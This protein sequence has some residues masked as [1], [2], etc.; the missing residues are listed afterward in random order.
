M[1]S[2]S[3]D[4][5]G[6]VFGVLAAVLGLALGSGLALSS[7]QPNGRKRFFT[8]TIWSLVWAVASP[9]LYKWTSP[10]ELALMDAILLR[11]LVVGWP[12]VLAAYSF[13]AAI[14]T[15]GI[16][17]MAIAKAFSLLRNRE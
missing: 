10:V 14:V 15:G 7:D 9:V 13:A 3:Y 17:G 8:W 2:A 16:A 4:S 1:S 12:S 5:F 11:R 6:W